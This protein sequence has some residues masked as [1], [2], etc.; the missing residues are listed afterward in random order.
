[1]KSLLIVAHG[2]RREQSND[3]IKALVRKMSVS[4]HEF[5]E[6]KA[7]FLEIAAPLI[8]DAIR[9]LIK[10]GANEVVIVPYFLSSGRHLVEDIPAEVN[11]VRTEYPNIKIT[12]APYLGAADEMAD[13]LFKQARSSFI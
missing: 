10:N 1:M 5:F 2:S 9:R 12:I 6:I 4:S 11:I 3:E 13:I 8:P 7:A